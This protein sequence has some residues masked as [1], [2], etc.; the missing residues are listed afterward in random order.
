MIIAWHDNR[1][2][3]NFDIYAQRVDSS[4]SAL[5]TADG[6][7]L[8]TAVSNQLFSAVISDGAGGAIVTWLDFR[9]GTNFDI[10]AQ[11]VNGSGNALWSVAGVP[12][13]TAANNQHDQRI[14]SDGA[15]GGIIT[16]FDVRSGTDSDIYAQR[17]NG[18]GGALWAVD[19]VPVCTA[20]NN[21]LTPTIVSDGAGGAV[22]A[23]YDYRSGTDYDI[24]ARRVDNSGSALW[25]ADGVPISTTA[26]NQSY[27][28]IVSDGAGGAI[29]TWH[30]N[31]GGTD[32]DIY[33]QQVD[34]EMAPVTGVGDLPNRIARPLLLSNRP[35][36]FSAGTQVRFKL[37]ERSAVKLEIVDLSGRTVHKRFWSEL[38]AGWQSV[39][40]D[41][42]DLRGREL[43]RGVYVYRISITRLTTGAFSAE[44]RK[45]VR[46]R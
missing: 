30:D 24:Y 23:W 3:T 20:A 19:G 12:I 25:T 4:G 44:T 27:P 22:I 1:S 2:G 33:A 5:W 42:R 9:S 17:V 40:F 31:R 7:P 13:C 46:V 26:N 36:P 11:R 38:S 10:Y 8:C 18:S 6:V 29:I 34:A 14:V 41:G 15:G 39:P 28:T 16:W 35:N 43:P 45:M 32:S 37:P 21:Q